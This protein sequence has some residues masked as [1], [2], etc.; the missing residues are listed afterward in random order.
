MA[1]RNS[2]IH[3]VP[4]QAAPLI[5]AVGGRETDEFLRQQEIYGDAWHGAGLPLEIVPMPADQHFSIVDGFAD[6]S[7]PLFREVCRQILGR[8]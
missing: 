3:L 4:R 5:L 2:P 6:P 8:A 1:R 7:N